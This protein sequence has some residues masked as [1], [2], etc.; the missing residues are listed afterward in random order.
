MDSIYTTGY[1]NGYS[2]GK[3]GKIKITAGSSSEG[4]LHITNLNVI[5]PTGYTT[6]TC[7]QTTTGKQGWLRV[8]INGTT[9]FGTES[10]F[11]TVY[12]TNIDISN[13]AGQTLSISFYENYKDYR[14][15]TV[16]LS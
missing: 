2:T 14:E 5:L 7:T 9:V 1:N 13:K 8:K 6:L 11:T 15:Y 4:S 12:Q 10:A 16:Y 3:G